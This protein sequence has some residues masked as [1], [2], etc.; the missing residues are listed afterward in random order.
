[1]A[2]A[3]SEENTKILEYRYFANVIGTALA[4]ERLDSSDSYNLSH[5]L[6]YYV[7]SV[8]KPLM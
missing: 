8:G 5:F 2:H 6:I 3:C 7:R 4:H 1:M